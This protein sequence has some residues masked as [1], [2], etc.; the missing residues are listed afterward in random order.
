MFGLMDEV[1]GY[2]FGVSVKGKEWDV[3]VCLVL[4]MWEC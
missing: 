2:R 4:A 3:C 1:P